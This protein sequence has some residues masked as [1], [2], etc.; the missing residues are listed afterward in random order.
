MP[1]ARSSF[2]PTD[3]SITKP[4]TGTW[5]RANGGEKT[6]VDGVGGIVGEIEEWAGVGKIVNG[7]G[8]GA[9]IGRR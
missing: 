7:D 2:S 8:D 6:V 4:V 3:C 9:V 1:V 5:W